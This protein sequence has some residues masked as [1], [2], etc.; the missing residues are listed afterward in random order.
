MGAKESNN[1]NDLNNNSPFFPG[2]ELNGGTPCYRIDKDNKI[3]FNYEHFEKDYKKLNES[4]EEFKSIFKT[5]GIDDLKLNNLSLKQFGELIKD[6]E[7]LEEHNLFIN[8]ILY[9]ILILLKKCIN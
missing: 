8:Q 2:T 7:I 5:E 6:Q 1:I 4:I 3:T 9:L